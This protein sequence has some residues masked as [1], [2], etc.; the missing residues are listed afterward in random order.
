V[1]FEGPYGSFRGVAAMEVRQHQ[2]VIDIID[3]E[4]ILQSG[5]C[6]IVESLKFWLE[7]IDSELL[8]DGIICFDPF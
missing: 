4:E 3:S 2:F 6:L 7:T 1:F 5:R 8:M